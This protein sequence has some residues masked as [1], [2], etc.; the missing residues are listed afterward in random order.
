MAARHSSPGGCSP[1][2]P[3]SHFKRVREH[4]RKVKTLLDSTV[5]TA[6]FKV[7]ALLDSTVTN[8]MKVKSVQIAHFLPSAGPLLTSHRKTVLRDRD[9]WQ[10]DI[11]RFTYQ[12]EQAQNSQVQTLCLPDTKS[13]HFVHTY[14]RNSAL[15]LCS[16]RLQL[17]RPIRTARALRN[18]SAGG[19]RIRAKSAIARRTKKT[20]ERSTSEGSTED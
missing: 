1:P 7:K 9:T 13:I 17:L 4:S 3:G 5:T 2:T 14:L 19:S 16:L 15:V 8:C 6:L 12:S 10:P 11:L 18:T 20:R